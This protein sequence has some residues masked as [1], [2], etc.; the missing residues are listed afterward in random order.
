MRDTYCEEDRE[1]SEVD[2]REM[3]GDPV[4]EGNFTHVREI[5]HEVVCTMT[6]NG[7]EYCEE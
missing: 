4:G 1:K 6:E 3:R 7:G 5:L 2:D